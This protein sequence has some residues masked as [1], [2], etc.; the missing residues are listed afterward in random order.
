MLVALLKG[1]LVAVQA[2]GVAREVVVSVVTDGLRARAS[3]PDQGHTM[4]P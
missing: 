2:D 4:R 1:M 3:A